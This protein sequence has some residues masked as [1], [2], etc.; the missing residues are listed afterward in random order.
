MDSS[1]NE[2]L[3]GAQFNKSIYKKHLKTKYFNLNKSKKKCRVFLIDK[4]FLIL[5]TSSGF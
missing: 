4:I 5:K 3:D 1:S 2:A